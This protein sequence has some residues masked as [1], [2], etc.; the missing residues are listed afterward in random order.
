MSHIEC[1]AIDDEPIALS[2]I[3]NFCER[4]GGLTLSTFCSV[5]S[6]AVARTSIEL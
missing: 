4:K 1:I 5:R 2:I 3:S 6:W